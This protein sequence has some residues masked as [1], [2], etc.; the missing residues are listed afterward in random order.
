M[1][2]P[3]QR[4]NSSR[5]RRRRKHNIK[6][7]K[8]VQTQECKNCGEHKLPHKVCDACGT[9]RGVQYKE[10]VKKVEA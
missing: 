7:I 3:K 6:K 5:T 10:V 8:V 4:Q 2:V 1:A 9:Y